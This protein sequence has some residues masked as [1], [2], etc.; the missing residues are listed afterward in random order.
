MFL[1]STTS[2]ISL[3][4]PELE[5]RPVE[6]GVSIQKT[7]RQRKGWGKRRE[8][9]SEV[10]AGNTWRKSPPGWVGFK[11]GVIPSLHLLDRGHG[12]FPAAQ[13][14]TPPFHWW[15]HAHQGAE[16]SQAFFSITVF[17]VMSLI[18]LRPL[19]LRGLG[20]S[21]KR[22]W[23]LQSVILRF[24]APVP[25]SWPMNVWRQKDQLSKAQHK[26]L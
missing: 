23:D 25:H 16:A 9:M 19:L 4:E 21:A 8:D 24:I 22:T 20:F 6:M 15:H 2:V 11:S 7:G 18:F 1:C 17:P 12:Q 13:M 26:Q 5:D 14:E 3:W 10:K